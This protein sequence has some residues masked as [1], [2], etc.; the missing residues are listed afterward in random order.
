MC[1]HT[2]CTQIACP[3]TRMHMCTHTHA[4]IYACTHTCTHTH[5]CRRA[6]VHTH[7][8]AR[9]RTHTHVHTP[10]FLLA[11][12]LKNKEYV[13]AFV[14]ML[15]APNLLISAVCDKTS[16]QSKNKTPNCN[17]I[18]CKYTLLNT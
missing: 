6:R 9:T 10:F 3:H 1:T 12:V 17:K 8:H 4:R 13:V 11:Q 5:T 16:V 14:D 15:D 2:H 18:L 7:A